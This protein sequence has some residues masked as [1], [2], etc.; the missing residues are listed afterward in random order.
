MSGD[1]DAD[2]LPDAVVEELRPGATPMLRATL[3]RFGCWL[4]RKRTAS[5]WS[6]A[7]ASFRTLPFAWNNDS[8]SRMAAIASRGW[9][10]ICSNRRAISAWWTRRLAWPGFER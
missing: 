7:R 1:G 2:H 9:R 10:K 3:R 4:A 6:A 8:E 5:K